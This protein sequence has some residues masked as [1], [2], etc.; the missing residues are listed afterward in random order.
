MF[1]GNRT[2]HYE[3]KIAKTTDEIEV[4]SQNHVAVLNRKDSVTNE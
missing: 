3:I 4:D 1:M 2:R